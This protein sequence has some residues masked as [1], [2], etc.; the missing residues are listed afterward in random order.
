MSLMGIACCY[1]G[2]IWQMGKKKWA[3]CTE[4][5]EEEEGMYRS[6]GWNEAEM[7]FSFYTVRK[8]EEGS[9]ELHPW[10]NFHSSWPRNSSPALSLQKVFLWS[11]FCLWGLLAI[12]MVG[13]FFW[14]WSRKDLVKLRGQNFADKTTRSRKDK[15]WPRG[16]IIFT[17]CCAAT[18]VYEFVFPWFWESA[19]VR[20]QLTWFG[21]VQAKLVRVY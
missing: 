13:P 3:I 20:F 15:T 6:R 17:S 12:H 11:C 18:S 9:S 1:L 16:P 7:G 21:I 10:W 14:S 2:R 19:K 8:Q 5:E 4:E